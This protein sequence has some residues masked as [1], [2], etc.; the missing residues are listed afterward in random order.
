MDAKSVSLPCPPGIK[1]KALRGRVWD[2]QKAPD[3]GVRCTV[4]RMNP[5]RACE[6]RTLKEA[7]FLFAQSLELHA[8]HPWLGSTANVSVYTLEVSIY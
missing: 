2:H 1:T 4:W 7:I 3:T 8:P 6:E 5:E